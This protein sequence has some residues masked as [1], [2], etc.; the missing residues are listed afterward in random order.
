VIF[1]REWVLEAIK[2]NTVFEDENLNRFINE[3]REMIAQRN[4][5]HT[6]AER[7]RLNKLLRDRI[8]EKIANGE[9]V[10]DNTPGKRVMIIKDLVEGN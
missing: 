5:P 4:T 3:C 8:R 7:I 1:L 2:N 6:E 9:I 10:Y